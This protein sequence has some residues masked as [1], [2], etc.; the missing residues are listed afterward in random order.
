M[1]TA[2]LSLSPLLH[3]AF[4]P[5]FSSETHPL[6]H[7]AP[8][9]R[10]GYATGRSQLLNGKPTQPLLSRRRTTLARAHTSTAECIGAVPTGLSERLDR[11]MNFQIL[12]W[13]KQLRVSF[14]EAAFPQILL[15]R[16][17]STAEF[18]FFIDWETSIFVM[19][20]FLKN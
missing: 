18:G 1:T 19:L 10:S 5:Q 7:Q 12:F 13:E 6:F 11:T 20:R 2:P 3:K 15:W 4:K 8:Y 9:L 17:T 16:H 14:P